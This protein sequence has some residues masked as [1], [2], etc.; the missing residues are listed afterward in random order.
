MKIPVLLL[1]TGVLVA[2]A[3][4]GCSKEAETSWAEVSRPSY[5]GTFRISQPSPK[6]LDPCFTSNVYESSLI[7]Q[8]FNGLVRFDFHLNVVPDIAESW[9]IEEGGLVYE[10]SLKQGVTFHNGREVT[11]DDFIYTISRIIKPPEG[12]ASLPAEY[13]KYIKGSQR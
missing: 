7:N 5:G 8:V 13:L 12:Y 2:L 9:T 11:A 4:S 10:F 6:T 3:V 1:L